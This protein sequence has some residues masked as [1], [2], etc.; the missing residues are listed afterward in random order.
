MQIHQWVHCTRRGRKP[1]NGLTELGLPDFTLGARSTIA[2][3]RT[4]RTVHFRIRAASRQSARGARSTSLHQ[5]REDRCRTGAQPFRLPRVK[6][7]R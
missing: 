4:Y 5:H 1:F 6:Q 2:F 7:F 3:H